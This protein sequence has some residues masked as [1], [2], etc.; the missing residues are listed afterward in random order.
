MASQNKR[1]A[2][3]LAECTS[4]PPPGI[5]VTLPNDS[6]LHKWHVTL[7]GPENSVYAGGRFGL[8]VSLPADYPFRAPT[9]TFATRIYHPNVTNDQLGNICLGP[10]KAENWKPSTRL[11]GVLEAVRALLAEPQPDDPLEARIA[12]EFR[13]ERQEF[14]KNAR[15]YVQRYAKGPV[16]FDVAAVGAAAAGEGGEDKKGAGGAATAAG[17]SRSG[18][19]TASGP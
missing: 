15:S 3:E 8:V 10:L 13:A 9:V 6:D 12:D 17:A 16:K 18:G 2:K 1:I 7:D 5:T 19:N 11:A 14:D 4:S